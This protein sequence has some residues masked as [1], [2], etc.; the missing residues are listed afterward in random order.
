MPRFCAATGQP[1]EVTK[2]DLAFLEEVSPVYCGVH[3][4]IPAPKLYP[5][6]RQARRLPFAMSGFTTGGPLRYRAS[7]S[8]RSIRNMRRFH[9]QL[10]LP[11]RH[12]DQRHLLRKQ[13]RNSWSLWPRKCDKTGKQIRSSYAPDRPEKTYCEEAYLAEVYDAAAQKT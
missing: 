2:G 8:H 12:P 4:T 10:G 1:F 13:L 5:E 9:M 11:G 3:Y 6:E 7:R